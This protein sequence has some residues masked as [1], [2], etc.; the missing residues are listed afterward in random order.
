MLII[1]DKSRPPFLSIA[2]LGKENYT[3]KVKID[4]NLYR[5]EEA[6]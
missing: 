2:G 6:A 4:A 3:G 1:Q 5:T